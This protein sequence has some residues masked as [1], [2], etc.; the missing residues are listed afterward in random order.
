MVPWGSLNR[1]TEDRRTER[2]GRQEERRQKDNFFLKTRAMEAHAINS[3]QKPS[4]TG[5]LLNAHH[6]AGE[7]A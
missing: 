4:A 5:Y 3:P 7:M 2:T 1:R 6:Q